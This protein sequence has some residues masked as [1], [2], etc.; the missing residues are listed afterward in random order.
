MTVQGKK[1][2]QLDPSGYYLGQCLE[3]RL[4][5]DKPEVAW[6]MDTS[7]S[8]VVHFIEYPDQKKT[9]FIPQDSLFYVARKKRWHARIPAYLPV[10]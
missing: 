9:A 1:I 8:D 4:S 10:G 7:E 5:L 3:R 6:R 2:Q